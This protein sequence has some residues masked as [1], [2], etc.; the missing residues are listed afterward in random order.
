M[1][2]TSAQL[3]AVKTQLNSGLKPLVAPLSGAI[4][5]LPGLS[6]AQKSQLKN[7]P[8]TFFLD[9]WVKGMMG[10]S[11]ARSLL[12]DVYK[13]TGKKTVRG[14]RV[15]Y[16]RGDPSLLTQMQVLFVAAQYPAQLIASIRKRA[17]LGSLGC[18]AP[19]GSLGCGKKDGLGCAFLGIDT[20]IC[21]ALIGLI[22]TIAVA[23]IG[24]IGPLIIAIVMGMM[25]PAPSTTQIGPAQ[26]GPTALPGGP[27]PTFDTGSEFPTTALIVGGT[28]LAG[29]AAWF[30]FGKRKKRRR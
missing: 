12:S 15:V 22:G 30:V 28:A 25:A 21:V 17:G 26:V 24:V 23:L 6:S 10:D 5:A 4:N 2:I 1:A 7:Y 3:K 27:G 18:G 11:L 29:V 9:T 20:V 14:A 13:R 19:L 16:Q 8:A